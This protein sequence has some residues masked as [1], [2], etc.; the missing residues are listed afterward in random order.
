MPY[1]K[2]KDLVNIQNKVVRIKRSL[3]EV[4]NELEKYF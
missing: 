1:M 4:Y 2:M 3:D